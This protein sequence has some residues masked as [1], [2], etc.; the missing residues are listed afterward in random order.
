[1]VSKFDAQVTAC[2]E[3]QSKETA[4]QP[5]NTLTTPPATSHR[6]INGKTGILAFPFTP[7][8]LGN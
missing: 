3:Q 8:R 1:M 5:T 4:S 7:F 6:A 2:S